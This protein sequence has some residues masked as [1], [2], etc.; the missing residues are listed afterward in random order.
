MLNK[1][2]NQQNK[3][4]FFSK[5]YAYKKYDKARV[6]C[7]CID[8]SQMYLSINKT[9]TLRQLRTLFSL[10]FLQTQIMRMTFFLLIIV[11]YFRK[12]CFQTLSLKE[13]ETFK[14]SQVLVAAT[15]SLCFKFKQKKTLR[16]QLKKLT[17]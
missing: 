12:Q 3:S 13:K 15:T 5:I 6:Y 9:I 16:F 14:K 11:L 8:I 4:F 10:S 17:F 7:S 1:N 2:L